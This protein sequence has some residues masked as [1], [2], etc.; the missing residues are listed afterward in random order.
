MN[1]VKFESMPS[2]PRGRNRVLRKCLSLGQCLLFISTFLTCSFAQESTQKE[3][4]TL[5]GQS[6]SDRL[7][8]STDSVEPI[9]FVAVHGRGAVI[10]GYPETGLEGWV[11]PFQI[12]SN[13]KIGFRPAG[14]TTES[15][16]CL[17]L[18]RIIYQ[19]QAITRIYIGLDYIVHEKLFVPL[20]QPGAI[21]SY[22][23]EG[24]PVDIQI[25]FTPVL[26]LMW[27]AAMGGQFTRWHPDLSGY[28]ISE[29]LESVSA[30]IASREIAAHDDTVNTTLRTTT[31]ISFSIRPVASGK[32]PAVATIY[33]ALGTGD[34]K[35]AAAI[36]QEMTAHR[37]DM[38]AHA[39][40][41]YAEL[42]H[43]ALLIHTPDEDINRA[44]TWAEIALDQTWVCNPR[45]GCGIVAGYGPSRD[46]RRPQYD[47]FFG[48][49]GLVTT[50][51][52][53][54]AGE[55]SRAREELEFI[56][57]YQDQKTGMI[58]HELSQSA[59][60]MDW[61]KYPYMYVHVDI[62]FDYLNTV[63]RYVAASGDTA[64]AT[65]HWP[66]ILAAY[67][68]CQALIN[69]SDHL[70]HIPP[71]KEGGDEQGVPAED[72]G[73]STNWV[74]A[75]QSLAELA[76]ATGHPQMADDALNANQLARKSIATRFWDSGRH[77]WI[78]G[79]LRSGEEI[80]NHS[81]GPSQL[82]V[83]NVFSPQQNEELLNQL[84]S[85]DF[86]ADWGMRGIAASS[87][88]FDPDSYSRGSISALG[89]TEAAVAFWQVHRPNIALGVWSAIL[90]WNSLDAL[91]H[92]H[93]VL[94][95][96]FYH[97]EEESVPEQTWSSAGFLDAAVRGFTGLDIQGT[98]NSVHFAPHL[99]AQWSRFSV[100][101]V[102][103]PKSTLALSVSQSV[104]E[105]DLDI[106]NEGSPAKILFEPQIPLGARVVSADLEGHPIPASPEV[107]P[108]DEHAR[109]EIEA[110]S[111][112][113]H[114]HIRFTGGVSL[115]LA[116][117][118]PQVGDPSTG[119]KLTKLNLQNQILSIDADVSSAGNAAFIIRTPWEIATLKGATIRPLSDASYEVTMQRAPAPA[120]PIG[121][122]RA[123]AEITF[124]DK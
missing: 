9:R 79:Y 94:A 52:L 31:T 119:L 12:F 26:N 83:Q 36:L 106:Q 103:L 116:Q 117:P 53:L 19:P 46:A 110:P 65:D 10:M 88:V 89:T 100:E 92:I 113:S 120:N 98:R 77:F 78:D 40:A 76:S 3:Q 39:T 96:N 71:G 43:D 8:I 63:A 112:T 90:P 64:F 68:Y 102:H 23:V 84:A 72:I 81:R 101:H 62:S 69:T 54:A 67:R 6:L 50:N 108:E 86:Q 121:Y 49:D 14:A 20:D 44:L 55:Y 85:S 51:A 37:T 42:E 22:E 87:H 104:N 28:V 5:D 91:G 66:S 60:Y 59:G 118:S 122:A 18:R 48:G 11:Y 41:H 56:I 58:W 25:H 114:C 115:I 74:A 17:Q 15:D 33:V 24:K 99:P 82:I 47:W 73:L 123:H 1:R 93:E 27:P 70:P 75:T 61:S 111:G 13:Y 21:L 97:E 35:N 38:E 95:G 29:P 107:F 2:E 16:G 80:F 30:V 57:K 4:S 7:A 109:V 124:T 105:V 34:S 32:G 45:I